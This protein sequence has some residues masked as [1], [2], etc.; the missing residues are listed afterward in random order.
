MDENLRTFLQHH[1]NMKYSLFLKKLKQS[2][3]T[4]IAQL[5][6]FV[7][8]TEI[9]AK[10]KEENKII[11]LAAYCRVSSDSADQLH[12]FA[13][14]I[15]YY[16]DYEQKHPEYKLVDIYADEGLTGTSMEKR[17]ELNRLIRDC[18]KGKIDRIVVKSVSRFARNTQELLVCIRLLK[19]LGI[20]VYFEEQGIDTDKLNME[21]IVTFPG[22]AAQ[23][24]SESISGNMRWSYKKRMESGEFN[25]CN[26]AYGYILKDGQLMINEPQAAIIRRIF[27]LY[28]SG[29]GKQSIANILNDEGVSRRYGKDKWYESTVHYILNNERYMGDALLQKS[30]TTETLPFKRKM[31]HGELPKY[32]VENSNPP[33]VSREIYQAVQTLQNS[34][35]NVYSNSK[36]KY[37]LSKVMRCPDCGMT[38]RRQIVKGTAYWLCSNK[39][40]SMTDCRPLRLKETAVY[41]TFTMLVQKLTDNRKTLLGDLIRQVEAMQ[42]RTSDN[43]DVIRRIDKKIADLAAQN[44]VIARLHTNGVINSAEFSAQSSEI[45]NKISTLRTKR[46]KKLSDDENDA[47][48][49]TLNSLNEILEAYDPSNNFDE[50]LFEKIVVGI[51]VNSNADLTFK[52]IGDIELTEEIPLKGRCRRRENS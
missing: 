9:T 35:K 28:L 51:T 24:E 42:N 4:P 5:N 44:L 8:V 52:L 46:R 34:R 17:D 29:V 41:E 2:I 21:M 43:I 12:S 13:A 16:K 15:R 7:H 25:C 40:A 10:S 49:D 23:Q 19:E 3:Y 11:R 50:E 20:S 37:L 26:P 27:D 14:Q 33:I 31:N 6:A 30:Y 32:Y 1:S 36:G 47:W 22:M 38:F 45:N 39:A 18:K 48:F